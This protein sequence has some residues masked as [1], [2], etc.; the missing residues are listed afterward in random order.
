MSFDLFSQEAAARVS[1]MPMVSA[2]E[3]GA[4][5]NFLGGTATVAM[6][7]FAKAGRSIDLLGA[8][9]PIATDAIT[10]G[11]ERQDR[12]FKE[13]DDVFGRAVDF[14]TPKPGEVGAAGEIA[15]QL[16]SAIPLV[17]GSPSAFVGTT[18]L[19]VA[20]DLVRK[21]VDATKAQAVGGV[22]AAGMGVGIWLPILGQNLWQRVAL[23]G[24][25]FNALQGVVT[26]G[27]SGA[28]LEGT[29]AA[30]DFKAFDPQQLTLD[31]LLG[32]AFGTLAHLSPAQRAQGAETWSR[33]KEWAGTLDPSQVDAIATLRQAQH[34]NVDSAPGRP[35]TNIDLDRHVQAMRK[36]IDDLVNDRPVN[37]TELVDGAKFLPDAER[38]KFQ[39]AMADEL[40]TQ[41]RT[42]IEEGAARGAARAD[43]EGTPGFLRSAEQQL[44]LREQ[45]PAMHPDIARAIEIARKPGFE[46]TA[47]EKLFLDSML[48]GR[49]GDFLMGRQELSPIDV[50]RETQAVEA[51]PTADPVALEA[52][53]FAES[54]PDFEIRIGENADGTPVT[55]KA[56]E[57]LDDTAAMV[58]QAQDD[59]K[60]FEVAAACMLGVR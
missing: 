14:W 11:T 10:G 16:L 59:A 38:A 32:A 2:P 26:R 55:V 50:P 24:A 49:A 22:Q 58:A 47:T 6:Q 39:Q 29:A 53:R 31:V 35:E 7:G 42:L 3:P 1:A 19:G 41:A 8:L 40:A 43:A 21:G 15:G 13:H 57:L 18:Q 60:L 45:D 27:A 12:Y 4:F 5:K 20:E 17:I 33:I 36:A 46:R 30:D 25:G 56:K 44:A 51:T 54:N 34:L 48:N 23:G 37:V 52:Q 9:G 28:I